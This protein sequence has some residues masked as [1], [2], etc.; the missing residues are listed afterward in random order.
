MA[1]GRRLHTRSGELANYLRAESAD[2]AVGILAR[3]GWTVVAGC[4]DYYC[5]PSSRPLADDV[6]D[7]TG[8]A[9]ARGIADAQDHWR[10]G[11]LTTWS[12]IA[13]S[14]DL[15]ELFSALRHAARQIGGVQ[16]QNAG[17]IGGNLCN[18]SPAADG[19]PPLLAMDAAVELRSATGMRVLPLA[20]F[21]RGNRRTALQAGELLTAIL[22]PKRI[23]RTASVF[24]KLGARA[25]QLISIVM[26]AVVIEADA[27]DQ[28]STAA[29]AVGAC[30][31]VAQRLPELEM[32]LIGRSLAGPPLSTALTARHL[33]ALSPVSDVRATAQYRRDAAATLVRRALDTA[34]DRLR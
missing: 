5:S 7:V 22:I 3:G 26:V 15:P 33:G 28:V 32:A 9:D 29:V 18:A 13:G 12:E 8:L 31:T 1:A 21:I 19:V 11:A 6:L 30:S 23:A 25:Y 2:E 17:T 20:D 10:L 27:E 16:I 24:V 34:Q 14:N 4:T